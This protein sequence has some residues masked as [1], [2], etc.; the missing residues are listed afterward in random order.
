MDSSKDRSIIEQE[1]L[2]LKCEGIPEK[3]IIKRMIEEAMNDEDNKNKSVKEIKKQVIKQRNI[4][5]KIV[6]HIQHSDINKIQ[7]IQ[8]NEFMEIK[9]DVEMVVRSPITGK[10]WKYDDE[11]TD[12]FE[13]MRIKSINR[14]KNK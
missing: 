14:A 3:Q 5:R 8:R 2:Q 11:L 9:C 13:D 4:E 10:K 6:K 12:F 7:D 1:Y